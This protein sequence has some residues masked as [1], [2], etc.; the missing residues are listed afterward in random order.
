[1][2]QMGA[3]GAL[4]PPQPTPLFGPGLPTRE[5]NSIPS[6]WYDPFCSVQQAMEAAS[7]TIGMGNQINGGMGQGFGQFGAAG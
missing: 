5:G 3:F 1:M 4:L 2:A 7:A 6:Y